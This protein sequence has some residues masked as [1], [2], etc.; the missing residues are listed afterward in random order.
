LNNQRG[1]ESYY[2]QKGPINISNGNL[3]LNESDFS[4]AAQGNLSLGTSRSYNSQDYASQ[5]IDNTGYIKDWLVNGPFYTSSAQNAFKTDFLGEEY[6]WPNEGAVNGRAWTKFHSQNDVLDIHE[7]LQST[8]QYNSTKNAAVYNFIYVW[9]PNDKNG[10]IWLGSDDGIKVFVNGNQVWG[11]N[12][13]RPLTP[14]SDRFN[15][16]LRTGWNRI[17][18]KVSQGEVEFKLQA[19]ICDVNGNILNDLKLSTTN[20]NLKINSVLG[21]KWQAD[22]E[23]RLITNDSGNITYIDADGSYH[24]FSGDGINYTRPQGLFVDL[25]RDGEKRTHPNGTMIKTIDS[26]R[27]YLIQDGKRKWIPNPDVLNSYFPVWRYITVSNVEMEQYPMGDM[28]NYPDGTLIKTA[29][30]P[31]VY[32]IENQ[33]KRHFPD[34]ATFIG[35]GYNWENVKVSDLADQFPEGEPIKVEAKHPSGSLIRVANQPAVYL[36]ENGKKNHVPSPSVFSNNYINWNKIIAIS[37]AEMNSYPSGTPVPYRDGTMFIEPGTGPEAYV[38]ENGARRWIPS[39]AVFT[40]AGY[41][42]GYIITAESFTIV[43]N[44][45]VAAPLSVRNL[46]LKFKDGI[47]YNFDSSGRLQSKNDLNGNRIS[48]LYEQD[49]VVKILDSSGREIN[50]SYENGYLKEIIDPAGRKTRFEFNNGLLQKAYNVLNNFQEYFYDGEGKI[51]QIND[52]KNNPT[53]FSYDG[54][55]AV[56]VKNAVAAETKF[57]YTDGSKTEITDPL[58]RKVTNY[59]NAYKKIYAVDDGHGEVLNNEFEYDGNLNPSRV[60][61]E[62]GEISVFEYDNI[63]NRTETIDQL[64]NITTTAYNS[65]SNPLTITDPNGNITRYNYDTRENLISQADPLGN[66]T[67]YNYDQYGNQIKVTDPKGNARSF[68]YDNFGNLIKTIDAK[69]A[70]T[71]SEYDILGNKTAS[72]D[73]NGVRIEYQLDALNR[74]S[75]IIDPSNNAKET[76]YDA[77]SNIISQKDFKG[78]VTQ[79]EFDAVNR[80]I[81]QINP[82]ASLIAYQYDLANNRTAVMDEKGKKTGYEYD[83]RNQVVAEVKPDGTRYSVTYDGNGNITK[84][85]DPKGQNHDYGFDKTDQVVS[86]DSASADSNY[87]YDKNGNPTKIAASSDTTNITYDKNN[88]PLTVKNSISEDSTYNYDKDG[89]LVAAQSTVKDYNLGYDSRDYLTQLATQ[90]KISSGTGTSYSSGQLTMSSSGISEITNYEYDAAGNITKIIKP[91]SDVTLY[92]YDSS[93]RLINAKNQNKN[94]LIYSSYDLEY[95]ANYNI[96]KITRADGKINSYQY[97]AKNQLTGE[98]G[99]VYTY[100]VAGN[101]TSISGDKNANYIYDET[102]GNKL[103]RIEYAGGRTTAFAYDANGNIIEKNDSQFGITT[104]QYDAED[105]FTKAILPSGKTIEYIYDAN[106]KR[107][108]RLEDGNLIKYTYEGGK[109]VAEV[110]AAGKVIHSYTYDPEENLVSITIDGL[111]Y[112]YQYDPHGN[113]IGLSDYLGNLKISYDYDAWGNLLT[114]R[115][116]LDNPRL[117][118]GYYFDDDLGMYFLKTR[119]YDPELGRFLSKDSDIGEGSGTLNPYIY[120]DNNPVMKIDQNGKFAWLI[121]LVPALKIAVDVAILY[122]GWYYCFGPGKTAINNV[123]NATLPAIASIAQTAIQKAASAAS[124]Y[125]KRSITTVK[126]VIVAAVINTG[127]YDTLKA[128]TQSLKA[129]STEIRD[130]KTRLLTSAAIGVIL[131]HLPQCEV[132]SKGNKKAYIFHFKY[133]VCGYGVYFASHDYPSFWFPTGEWARS[134]VRGRG[135]Q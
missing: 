131:S 65:F 56:Q 88:A 13:L 129:L 111:P 76:Q 97:D 96:T 30:A 105:Y 82:D 107:I 60:I 6:L 77:N 93:G 17:L 3:N 46:R 83:D 92:A 116:Q 109:L 104:Y 63:G 44:H 32:V 98:N 69:G 86:S 125:Y 51:T 85:I 5:S 73:A 122:A 101:R 71:S 75:K 94:G 7:A 35:M 80:L 47:Y 100:D 40:D 29:N 4:I 55:K 64:G 8:I 16:S 134:Y 127:Y 133:G 68:V 126:S 31:A 12:V 41:N 117:Y 95:D 18:F 19:K 67:N 21:S 103:L 2:S 112:Y 14:D 62:K 11:N 119:M 36:V 54:G 9:S 66:V 99:T 79:Y 74:E 20:P 121:A 24:N 39:P 26:L 113:V 108:S 102:D 91:N 42:W 120:C 33:K 106:K 37:D 43:N 130:A 22:F 10:Q 114:D 110:D 23:Q 118:S 135:Y 61:D 28:L 45:P 34:P 90:T 15:I 1:S 124:S 115:G 53:Y 89:N 48:Y 78:N 52:F 58:A 57:N 70:T 84:V 50:L 123:V 81:K 128:T 25:I 87:V 27:I 132:Y 72:I 59:L 38:V 49:K